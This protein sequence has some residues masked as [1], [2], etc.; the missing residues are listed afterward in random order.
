[1]F[2]L[3]HLLEMVWC[4]NPVMYSQLDET[5]LECLVDKLWASIANHDSWNSKAREYCLL[6]H[7]F[8]APWVGRNTR[9]CFY[10]F[11]HIVHNHQDVLALLW[12]RGG[13]HEVYSPYVKNFHMKVTLQ[14]HSISGID[15]PVFLTSWATPDE[16]FGV[17]IH[18][19]PEETTLPNFCLGTDCSV[20]SSIRRGV[21]TLKNSSG[22]TKWDTATK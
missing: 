2:L 17:S 1:M 16:F 20:M 14:G 15:I 3:G 8:G 6:E 13:T 12:H 19:W 11:G 18:V 9:K 10:P 21:T 4:C 5:L 7:S 22:L